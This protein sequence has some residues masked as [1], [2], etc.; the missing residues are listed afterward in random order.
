MLLLLLKHTSGGGTVG[1]NVLHVLAQIVVI[2][3]IHVEGWRA[4][5]ILQKVVE[6][7]VLGCCEIAVI[8]DVEMSGRNHH[9][10]VVIRDGD[11]PFRSKLFLDCQVLIEGETPLR[12]V[13]RCGECSDQEQSQHQRHMS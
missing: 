4:S 8:D 11:V 2:L 13:L 6:N 12:R 3:G 10:A 5:D 7:P 9:R 1:E